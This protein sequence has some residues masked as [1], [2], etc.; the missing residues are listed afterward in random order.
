MGWHVARREDEKRIIIIGRLERKERLHN[1]RRR[2]NYKLPVRSLK[3]YAWT[4]FQCVCISAVSTTTPRSTCISMLDFGAVLKCS[5]IYIFA[6]A[7]F[8]WHND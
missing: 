5:K 1:P 3:M 8:K 6:P 2:Y 7:E 4:A